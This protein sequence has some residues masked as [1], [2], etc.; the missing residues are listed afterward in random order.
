M[1][2]ALSDLDRQNLQ[3]LWASAGIKS[4]ISPLLTQYWLP[5]AEAIASHHQSLS[6]PLIQGILGGQGTGKTTLCLILKTILRAWG[7]R[8]ESLSI[9]D[10]YKTYAER[11]A[12]Q[13]RDPRL[14]W[15]GPPGTHDVDLGLTVMEQ[16]LAQIPSIA[17]PQFDKYLHAGQG[18]R[19]QPKMIAPIDILLFE[20]WFVG[21]RSIHPEGFDNAPEP[22]VTAGDRQFARESNEALKVYEPLWDQLDALLVL[23]PVDYRLSLDWR[24]EAESKAIA[25][26]KTGMS[27]SEIT[28]FVHYFWKALHPELFISPLIQHAQRANYVIDI[29]AK[30]RPIKLYSPT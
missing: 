2:P 30:H 28:E 11:Q 19:T 8:A 4:D 9:D 16:V 17:L 20:G 14:I 21:T 3:S 18:D 26:G 23:N 24:W 25:Q 7:L 1:S 22:I 12:L 6:R 13:S 10:L 29:D 15:R 27:Q 5:L